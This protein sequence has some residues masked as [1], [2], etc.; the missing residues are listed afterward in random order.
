MGFPLLRSPW[1]A[2]LRLDDPRLLPLCT[3]TPRKEAEGRL[4]SE[5]DTLAVRRRS[6][7]VDM[8]VRNLRSTVEKVVPKAAVCG[9]LINFFHQPG[10]HPP[11]VGE[12]EEEGGGNRVA[13]QVEPWR[14]G[15]R[16]GRL[17]NGGGRPDGESVRTQVKQLLRRS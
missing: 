12:Q 10:H 8:S 1:M 5:M 13:R 3:P 7:R 4:A 11:E 17:K 6:E 15:S 14:R 9:Y 16:G 2:L